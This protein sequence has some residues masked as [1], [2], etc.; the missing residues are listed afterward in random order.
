MEI[1]IS[2]RKY[3]IREFGVKSKEFDLIN[4]LCGG[5]LSEKS[6]FLTIC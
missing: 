6:H 1:S 2:W 5:L 3:S 4:P